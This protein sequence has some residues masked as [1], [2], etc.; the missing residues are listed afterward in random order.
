M[1]DA[2]SDGTRAKR[3]Q[4]GVF[5]AC[6]WQRCCCLYGTETSACP[7]FMGTIGQDTAHPLMCT[8]GAPEIK[9]NGNCEISCESKCL[10]RFRVSKADVFVAIDG[11]MAV[12]DV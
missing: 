8:C 9:C 2:G 6:R 7:R 5:R 10:F 1:Q 3:K 11:S 12:E 4:F